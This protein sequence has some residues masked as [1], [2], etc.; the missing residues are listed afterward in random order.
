MDVQQVFELPVILLQ[1][2]F[3]RFV[4]KVTRTKYA[5]R[6]SRN[7]AGQIRGVIKILDEQCVRSIAL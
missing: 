2:P 6:S 5:R 4:V 3:R 1:P 7:L